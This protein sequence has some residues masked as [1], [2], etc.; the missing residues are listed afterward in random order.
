[1]KSKLTLAA[2]LM[3]GGI[4]AADAQTTRNPTGESTGPTIPRSNVQPQSPNQAGTPGAGAAP[5]AISA[6]THCWDRTSNQAR[7][8]TASPSGGTGSPAAAGSARGSTDRANPSS[9]TASGPAGGQTT[10]GSGNTMGLPA[11]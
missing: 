6:Q 10:T 2:A 5:G 4:L 8:K 11:C 7:L 1:M 9:P 3:C